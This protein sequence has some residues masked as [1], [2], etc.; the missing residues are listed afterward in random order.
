MYKLA[1]AGL[2]AAVSADTWPATDTNL[3]SHW[4]ASE[5]SARSAGGIWTFDSPANDIVNGTGSCDVTIATAGVN[6]VHFFNAHVATYDGSG[7]WTVY[8]MAN[9]E[10]QGQF[11]F[12]AFSDDEPADGDISV[13][14]QNDAAVADG[15]VILGSFPQD[16]FAAD[17]NG[18]FTIQGDDDANPASVI[19]SFDAGNGPANLT[20]DDPRLTVDNVGDSWTISGVDAVNF[21]DIW[22]HMDYAT[23]VNGDP[24]TVSSYEITVTTA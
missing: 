3:T 20:V 17:A 8:A 10:D 15:S 9:W 11:S 22:F 24:I 13:T 19:L 2:L 4:P 7:T 21:D 16:P 5:N 18:V 14:C 6:F 1:A 12:L 23:D